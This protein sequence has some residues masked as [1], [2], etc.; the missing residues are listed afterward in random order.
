MT[1]RNTAAAPLQPGPISGVVASLRADLTGRGVPA[2]LV[3]AELDKLEAAGWNTPA[4]VW[5]RL[6]SDAWHAV[7]FAD[8]RADAAE[9]HPDQSPN[10]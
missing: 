4:D 7:M 5:L 2:D 8:A 9:L 6:A 1:A 3:R 10:R